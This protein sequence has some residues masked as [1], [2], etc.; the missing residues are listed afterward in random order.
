MR[1]VALYHPSSEWA[2]SVETYARD[3]ERSQGVKL[4]LVSLETRDGAAMASMYDILSYPAIMV[5]KE[6][7][8]MQQLWQGEQLPL[9]NEVVGFARA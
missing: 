1:I 7:G 5:I 9:M 3:I 8:Q 6:D 2:S 4:E